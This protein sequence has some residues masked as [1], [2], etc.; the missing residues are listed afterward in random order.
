M[1]TIATLMYPPQELACCISLGIYRDTR[2]MKLSDQERLNY[3]PASP[4]FA[5]TVISSGQLHMAHKVLDWIDLKS[6]PTLPALSVTSPQQTPTS[7]WSAGPVA[8]LTVGFYPDAWAVLCGDAPLDEI[9]PAIA[10]VF[11][12]SKPVCDAQSW[13]ELCAAMRPIWQSVRG[14]NDDWR[15]SDKVADWA[16]HI[17]MRAALSGTGKSLRSAE[18][19]L[20]RWTGHSQQS[21]KFFSKIEALQALHMS[22]PKAPLADIAAEADFSDQSHMGRA[23]KRATGFSPGQLNKLVET[24]EAFWC[25]RLLGERF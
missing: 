10:D 16:R 21:I 23:V 11:Q 12:R 19:R 4:L 2:G 3:F 6:R 5:I 18:R 24:D 8:A 25:Y 13:A 14:K 22:R 17:T 20:R 7:S 15:G 1:M 9:P